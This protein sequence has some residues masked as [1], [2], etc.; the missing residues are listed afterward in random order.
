MSKIIHHFQILK[1]KTK[2]CI[3]LDIFNVSYLPKSGK[4]NFLT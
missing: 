4:I 3:K 2:H 1:L